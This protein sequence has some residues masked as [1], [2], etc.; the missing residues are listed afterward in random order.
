MKLIFKVFGSCPKAGLI[1]DPGGMNNGNN[2]P[3]SGAE[4]RMV[5][6]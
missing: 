2:L 4:Q 1:V 5:E 6:R 3:L